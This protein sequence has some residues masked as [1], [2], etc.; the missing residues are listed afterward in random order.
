MQIE[1][2]PLWLLLHIHEVPGSNLD[3]ETV[4]IEGFRDFSQSFQINART[5]T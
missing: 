1:R 2:A 5:E 4:L 3:R